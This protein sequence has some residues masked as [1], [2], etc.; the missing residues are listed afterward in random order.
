MKIHSPNILPKLGQ[1]EQAAALLQ[2][3]QN[4]CIP[5]FQKYGIRKA[6]LFG[7]VFDNRSGKSPD[8]DLLVIPLP[9]DEYW[10]CRYEL[11]DALECSV[12]L[13]GQED[14]SWV[15]QKILLRGNVIYDQLE[16]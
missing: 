10:Q 9:D 16:H 2:D 6:I 8:V 3:A 5:I 13:C 4:R 15:T 12:D 11:E 7:S 1:E 14:D